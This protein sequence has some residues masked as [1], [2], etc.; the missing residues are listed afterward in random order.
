MLWALEVCEQWS[1]MD[2]RLLVGWG[3]MVTGPQPQ[4]GGME[5]WA[6]CLRW[7]IHVADS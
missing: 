7:L 1:K 3:L 2:L 4:F 5:S 6:G